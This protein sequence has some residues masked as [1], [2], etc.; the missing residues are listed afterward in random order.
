[1]S[2]NKAIQIDAP[3]PARHTHPWVKALSSQLSKLEHG[4]LSLTLPD[5]TSLHYGSGSIH[6]SVILNSYKPISELILKG[7]L[8][9][10]ESYLRGEWMCP[11]LTSLFDLA[12]KNE[13]VFSLDN[14]GGF[15]FRTLNRLR[16]LLNANSK[17]GSK[18]N[19]SY[20]YDLGNAFYQ[21]WLDDSMTY[22]SALF[23]SDEDIQSAQMNKY[24]TIAD[25]AELKPGERVLEIGCGWGGFSQVAAEEYHC[26]IEGLTLSKE[27]LAYANKRYHDHDIQNLAS[28]SLTDYRDSDGQYDKIV[29]IEMFE[30]VG[31]EN[32]DTYFETVYNRLKAGGS[33]VLQIILI[34]DERFDSYR[35]EVDFIQRYIFPGGLL[36]SIEALTETIQNHN[37]KLEDTLLFG[38]SYAKTCEIWQK[39]FQHAW[40]D[41]QPMGFDARFKRMWEYYLSYCIS[42]FKAGTI[43][44]GLFKI[45][46]PA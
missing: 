37:L 21:K 15:L 5:G 8:A 19:I 34:E 38:Q 20:H 18:R 26:R 35:K 14:R 25:M 11:D 40:D 39:N 45:N 28:A 43:D 23:K 17:R 9:L 30:A 10:A 27:Q 29:S 24:R 41:I 42:G 13:Q 16:H 36:P 44:V 12:L 32:W 31:Y 6:A 46:K 4:R 7:D 3:V 1:M 33:A 22:S 2:E